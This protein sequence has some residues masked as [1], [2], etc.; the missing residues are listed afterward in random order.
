MT[1][2]LEGAAGRAPERIGG[3]IIDAEYVTL[4]SEPT[5]AESKS[6]TSLRASIASPAAPVAG[7]D[8]LRRPREAAAPQGPRAA[9]RSSGSLGI[10][11]AA[12]AFWVSGGHALVRGSPFI[13][14]DA[15]QRRAAHFRRHL[16]RRCSGA[17]P[18]LFVDGEAANDGA[19]V[20]HLPPLD[21]VVTGNDGR[22]TRYRLGTS[23]RPWRRA[24]HSPFPAVSMCLRTG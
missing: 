8:M 11:L 9:G 5:R 4:T 6:S 2:P 7:M 24:K 17:R 23:G 13:G 16:A 20:A 10:G 19:A 14:A 21:I 18:I 3:D 15:P 22:I 1:D 12:A